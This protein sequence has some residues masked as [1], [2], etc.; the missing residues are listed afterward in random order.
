MKFV[1]VWSYDNYVPAHLDM[2]LLKQEGIESWLKD[3]HSVTINPALANSVGGIKLMV[4]ESNAQQAWDILIR[5]KAAYIGSLACPKC[6]SNNLLADEIPRKPSYWL[7]SV[8]VFFLG[9]TALGFD[10]IYRCLNCQNEFTEP[11]SGSAAEPKHSGL[12]S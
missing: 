11:V 9:D 3:E 4:A 8:L 5:E 10:K 6:G 1:P 2:N 7:E 12:S